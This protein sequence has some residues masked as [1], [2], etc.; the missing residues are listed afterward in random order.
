[1]SYQQSHLSPWFNFLLLLQTVLSLSRAGITSLASVHAPTNSSSVSK[2]KKTH[3]MTVLQ[4]YTNIRKNI[5]IIPPKTKLTSSL[6]I[7]HLQIRQQGL[8]LF[9]YVINLITESVSHKIAPGVPGIS[10]RPGSQKQQHIG[11]FI[12]RIKW[13]ISCTSLSVTR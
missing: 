4:H 2:K 9:H 8:H 13:I 3:R 5:S 10:G 12:L 1:M 6:P 7:N 11:M